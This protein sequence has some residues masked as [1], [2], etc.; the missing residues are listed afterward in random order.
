MTKIFPLL[1]LGVAILNYWP[2]QG[3]PTDELEIDRQEIV[4]LENE[5]ARA[6]QLGNATFFK[7]V[8]SEDFLGT[9]KLGQIMTKSMIVDAVQA[10]DTKYDSFFATDIHVRLYQET[11]VVNCLWTS[12]GRQH[13]QIISNQSRVMHVYIN[14]QRGW[15]AV[16]SQET[17]LPGQGQ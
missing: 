13:G 12:Y 2:P 8:Y 15:Q 17:P 10:S 14:G 4:N 6:M 7:R 1:A 16:A 5:T 3:K 11:A 9:A